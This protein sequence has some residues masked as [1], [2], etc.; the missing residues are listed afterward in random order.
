MM[1]HT[2]LKGVLACIMYEQGMNIFSILRVLALNYLW[3]R[4][5]LL[6]EREKEL[7]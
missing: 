3:E 5:R 2:F 7:A 1:V 4:K 6:L